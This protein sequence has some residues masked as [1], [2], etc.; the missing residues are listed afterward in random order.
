M[1]AAK[2]KRIGDFLSTIVD[3]TS[4]DNG[5]STAADSFVGVFVR[6]AQYNTINTTVSSDAGGVLS[7]EYSFNGVDVHGTSDGFTT[8]VLPDATFI[9][10]PLNVP[11]V[12]VAWV[13]DVGPSP[14]TLTIYTRLSHQG[15]SSTPLENEGAGVFLYDPPNSAIRSLV[16][17]DNTSY[18][19]Q[20]A[21]EIDIQ[22]NINLASTGGSVGTVHSSDAPDLIIYGLTAGTGINISSGHILTGITI[23]NSEPASSVT[24]ASAGGTSSLVNDGVGPALSVKGV[25]AGAGISFVDSGSAITITNSD[26]G[27]AV[28]LS[29]AGAGSTLVND[30]VGPAL[31][32]KSLIAG[33]GINFVTTSSTIQ[34]DNTT[35]VLS[36]Y[37]ELQYQA[38]P[39]AGYTLA[40]PASGAPAVVNPTPTLGDVYLYSSPSGGVL[41]YDDSVSRFFMVEASI[42]LDTGNATDYY[43]FTLRKNGVT[44][45]DTFKTFKTVIEKTILLRAIVNLVQNDTLSV[46]SENSGAGSINT[47]LIYYNLTSAHLQFLNN[48]SH[49]VGTY[50]APAKTVN[51]LAPNYIITFSASSAHPNITIGGTSNRELHVGASGSY[52]FAY[53]LNF[54]GQNGS[55]K[56]FWI[57]NNGASIYDSGYF[58]SALGASTYS[59]STSALSLTAGDIIT[60]HVGVAG[61][62]D[63]TFTL[64]NFTITT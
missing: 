34:I 17:T 57:Y 39:G 49:T 37:G 33:T 55:V 43:T 56:E 59:S 28:T 23:T 18:L 53:T 51:S 2:R 16:S 62:G 19:V 36:S 42:Y 47:E 9:G 11:Y 40:I 15:V 3:Y 54:F 21:E 60:V 50:S 44:I 29:S 38:A 63:C 32:T 35:T 45:L 24:L 13:K 58:G 7:F 46:Y 4:V 48:L 25:T 12:R 52:T 6:C 8:L 10:R 41:R 5:T 64:T 61:G 1:P 27:S 14:T 31:A 20:N 26:I 22:S 30:G